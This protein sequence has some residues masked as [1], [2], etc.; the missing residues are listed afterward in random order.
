M[1]QLLEELNPEQRLAATHVQGPALILA[2]AGS[3]K[4]KALTHRIVYLHMEKGVPLDSILAITFTN[5]AAREMKERVMRLIPRAQSEILNVSTFHAFCAKLLRREAGH[6]GYGNSFS[7]L[8]A[9]DSLTLIKKIMTEMGIDTKRIYPEAVKNLISSAKNELIGPT[10]YRGLASGNLQEAVAKIYPVYQ[11]R[12]QT[13]N[14]VDFDDLIMLTVRLFTEHP[15]VLAKYQDKFRYVLIDEY[16]DTNT[17]QY[18]LANLLVSAHR[19]LF[20]VGD[21]WQSIYS[22]RGANY[23]NILNFSKDYPEAVVV[24]LE[25]NYRST[26]VILDAAHA[27]IASNRNRSDKRLWTAQDSGDSIVVYEALNDRDEGEFVIRKVEELRGQGTSLNEIVVL[28]RTNAQSRNLEEICLRHDMPYRVVGGV[29]FYDRRE[30]RDMVAWLTLLQN[31]TNDV[32]VERIINVPTRGIGAKT[33]DQLYAR[34]RE[35]GSSLLDYIMNLPEATGGVAEFI[36]IVGRITDAAERMSISKLLDVVM[37]ETGYMDW[38]KTEGIEGEGRLEN[39]R[40]LKSVMEKYDHLP[41]PAALTAFLEEVSLIS[42]LDNQA[43][44]LEAIT[45]MTIHT[46]KGLEF[47]YV[48]VVGLE[49]NVFPH[50]RSLFEQAELE[51][52]RRL[53]YVAITRARKQIF[54]T[55]AKERL[56][57]GN[58]HN[59]PASRFVA[60][61]P[62]ELVEHL[63]RHTDSGGRLSIKPKGTTTTAGQF[64]PGKKVLHQQFGEGT[65]IAR[66]GDVVT[67]AFVRE[68]IKNLIPELANLKIKS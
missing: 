52:E 6:L 25:Q 33:L 56:L 68:G 50:S 55:Y 15:T 37:R 60:D 29:K 5:K 13:N 23:E 2:G 49:E 64:Q 39:V 44:D 9:N 48:F 17:A 45:L 63:A 32:A 40:E 20:V 58:V 19:N 21:D 10:E 22:W 4:T 8:D 65:V 14:A 42:D 34:A 46:A 59:N 66:S 57:Y 38:L 30:V 43:Q 27:V 11:E 35:A 31:P 47:D 61:I 51:E 67:I 12:L 28:Y 7:I 18:T 41:T 16:Q 3:G 62:D 26:Q 36:N 54:L 1:S 53:A 24:K